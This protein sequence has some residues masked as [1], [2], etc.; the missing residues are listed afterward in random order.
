MICTI[1]RTRHCD[2]VLTITACVIWTKGTRFSFEWKDLSIIQYFV[3]DFAYLYMVVG[4]W[5]VFL[6]VFISVFLLF[7]RVCVCFMYAS[8]FFRVFLIMNIYVL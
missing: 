4:M 2:G 5:R 1:E 3:Y 8:F 6:Q 7:F